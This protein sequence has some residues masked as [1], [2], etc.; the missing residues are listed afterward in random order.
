MVF[1]QCQ[2]KYSLRKEDTT[3][4]KSVFSACS[5]PVSAFKWPLVSRLSS[6]QG[7]TASCDRNLALNI[8][9]YLRSSICYNE[10]FNTPVSFQWELSV[11]DRYESK[12]NQT[13]VSEETSSSLF[14][15]HLNQFY[16]RISIVFLVFICASFLFVLTKYFYY[17]Y[18]NR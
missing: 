18:Y 14:L 17:Y 12:S 3:S 9:W 10:V 16:T 2:V 6:V 7:D 8:S 15:I 13:A 4:S 5:L 1:G 11:K